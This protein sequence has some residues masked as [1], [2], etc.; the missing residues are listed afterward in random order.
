MGYKTSC[1]VDM[2]GLSIVLSGR[3]VVTTPVLG[4]FRTFPPST[5]T[6]VDTVP[7][8]STVIISGCFVPEVGLSTRAL[9]F[10]VTI[11]ALIILDTTGSTKSGVFQTKWVIKSSRLPCPTSS[12]LAWLVRRITVIGICKPRITAP[13]K[14]LESTDRTNAKL[15]VATQ[16]IPT[17]NQP[18]SWEAFVKAMMS[19]LVTST[20]SSRWKTSGT[21]SESTGKR[22]T[23]ERIPK[24]LVLKVC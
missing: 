9:S 10:L 13:A 3:T 4:S 21:G 7:S 14:V 15:I 23:T 1:P 12:L 19:S 20:G 5:R 22:L 2:G 11:I 6:I 24:G 8:F 18:V 17:M 16:E